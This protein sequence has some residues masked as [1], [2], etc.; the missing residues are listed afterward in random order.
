MIATF[1]AKVDRRAGATFRRRF[2]VWIGLAG[3]TARKP[4]RWPWRRHG[5][6]LR[7]GDRMLFLAWG[8]LARAMNGADTRGAL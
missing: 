7:V 2:P 6:Y 8:P 4:R 3:W 1:Q 5:V